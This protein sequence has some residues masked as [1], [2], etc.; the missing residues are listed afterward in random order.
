MTLHC[1]HYEIDTEQATCSNGVVVS[2]IV[3]VYNVEDYLERCLESIINQTFSNIEII[4]V[5]DGSTDSSLKILTEY[6]N[7]DNRITVLTQENLHAG[8]ARNAG[9]AVA[10]GEYSAGTEPGLQAC[11]N[12]SARSLSAKRSGIFCFSLLTKCKKE[13]IILL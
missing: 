7:R 9:L 8:V 13:R 6:A 10:R 12:F 2:V 5:D 3:P 1:R 4:C 11:R